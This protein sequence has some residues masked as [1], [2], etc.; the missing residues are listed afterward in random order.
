MS[1]TFHQPGSCGRH[2]SPSTDKLIRD[3]VHRGTFCLVFPFRHVHN[4]CRLLPRVIPSL[5][6]HLSSPLAFFE[7]TSSHKPSSHTTSW[8]LLPPDFSWSRRQDLGRLHWQASLMVLPNVFCLSR[9][10]C[11]IVGCL[12][13]HLTLQPLSNPFQSICPQL[14]RRSIPRAQGICTFFPPSFVPICHR[15]NLQPFYTCS[16]LLLLKPFIFNLSPQLLNFE[17]P[18]LAPS[19]PV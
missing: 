13:Q 2:A 16:Y 4:L 8:D 14:S 11:S 1:T 9:G 12:H 19:P 3:F 18:L 6:P 17:H 7:C 5:L 15:L 10:N